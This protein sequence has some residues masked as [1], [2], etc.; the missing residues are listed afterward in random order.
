[1][2]TIIV[3]I[4]DM[5]IS[6]NPDDTL[7]TYS[8][9][10]CIGV[11]VYDPAI[12]VGGMIHCMLPLS[13]TDAQKAKER[14]S[15]FVDVGIPL[16]LNKLFAMGVKKCN[17]IVKVAGGARV[18]DKNDLFRIGERNY[19]VFRKLLWKNGMMITAEDVGGA[20]ARTIRLDIGTGRF[21]VRSN[22][23]EVEL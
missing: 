3:D 1:M 5:A 14:P 12:K 4:A 6:A 23:Q 15:M 7:I 13:S 20:E 2:S 19:T 18:L 22:R 8:L 10:S 21:T 17:A 9:G 16:M 11:V